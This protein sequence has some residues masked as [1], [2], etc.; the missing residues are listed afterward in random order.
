[1]YDFSITEAPTC[2]NPSNLAVTGSDL[3]SAI[4]S[5][6]AGLSETEWT[7]EYGPVGFTPG[8]GTSSLTLNNINDTIT[9]LAT[10]LFYEL[11][12]RAVCAPGDTSGYV[13][14]LVFNTYN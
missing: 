4:F 3:T 9:G 12:V 14:P 2:P 1:L 8:N 7:L 13:G 6:T 5:W 10:N 11:Y